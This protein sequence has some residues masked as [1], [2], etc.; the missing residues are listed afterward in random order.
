MAEILKKISYSCPFCDEEHE[1]SIIQEK[2]KALVNNTPV[3]YEEVYYHCSIEDEKFVP[4]EILNKNLLAAK[5]SYRTLNGLLTSQ[6]IKEVR[7]L[8][9]LSQKEFANLLGWGD[10]TIQRYEKKSIQDETYDQKIRSVKDNPKLALD[11]LERHKEKFDQERYEELREVIT[12]LVKT[13]SVKY[14]NKEVIESLY[15]DFKEESENNGYKL[16]DLEKIENMIAFF[17]Q[18]SS[19]LYKVKLMKFLWY[20]D[21]L[22][23]KKY[24][25]GMSGM[26]YR[27]LPL[28]AVP[29]AH[30]ELLRYSESSIE[31][32]EE[33]IDDHVAYRILPKINI[34]LSKF[35][36]EEISVLQAIVEKFDDMGSK[37]I[38]NY[39]HEEVAYQETNEDEIIPYSLAREI[40][41]F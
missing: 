37:K 32:V 14:L 22:F 31:V 11:E 19:R 10:V 40:R 29:K 26:V 20:A 33:Y 1:I 4:K 27:H 16:L 30:E 3:E 24:G 39:M 23:C 34:D 13:K 6:E 35:S 18:N 15:I 21:A 25:R 2:T 8:Y 38:S 41:D 12:S 36:V 5:D 28:G 17:A 7:N 9:G